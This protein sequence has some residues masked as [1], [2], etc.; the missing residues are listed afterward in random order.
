MIID[1]LLLSA[2]V[3]WS[4][5][6]ESNRGP[7]HYEWAPAGYWL[8]LLRARAQLALGRGPPGTGLLARELLPELLPNSGAGGLRGVT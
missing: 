6:S 3:T 8:V 5:L 1:V 7:V 2:L 4:R